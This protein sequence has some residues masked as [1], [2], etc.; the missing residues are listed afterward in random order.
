MSAQ[1]WDPAA[2]LRELR[3]SRNPD[4]AI[5]NY[6]GEHVWLRKMPAL[7]PMYP[8]GYTSDCC[9]IDEP[10]S[11]HATFPKPNCNAPNCLHNAESAHNAHIASGLYTDVENA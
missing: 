8:N 7:L 6:M 3:E 9:F 10:C 4:K 11:H 2:E 1:K 5:I